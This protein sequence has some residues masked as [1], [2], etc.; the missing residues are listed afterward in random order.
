MYFRIYE[1]V[2]LAGVRYPYISFIEVENRETARISLNPIPYGLRLHPI[3]YPKRPQMLD[4][5]Q[6]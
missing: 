4:E 6:K 3:P 2:N 1:G 5:A